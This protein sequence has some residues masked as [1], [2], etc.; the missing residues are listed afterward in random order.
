M[1]A[2]FSLPPARHTQ[3]TPFLASLPHK[4]NKKT[5][6]TPK[7]AQKMPLSRRKREKKGLE[8]VEKG[9]RGEGVEGWKREVAGRFWVKVAVF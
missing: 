5:R 3:R 8:G 1:P 9:D 6:K 7:K 4:T 2:G